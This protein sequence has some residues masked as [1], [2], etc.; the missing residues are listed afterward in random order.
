[1]LAIGDR[2]G[3][4]YLS[5]QHPFQEEVHI[6]ALTFDYLYNWARFTVGWADRAEA[7]VSRWRDV[8]PAPSKHGRA[9]RRLREILARGGDPA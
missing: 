7:E 9:L 3:D 6:R 4:L 5:G 8:R 1:M 2:I